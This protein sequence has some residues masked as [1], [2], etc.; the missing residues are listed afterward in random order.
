MAQPSYP[1]PDIQHELGG[2]KVFYVTK[3]YWDTSIKRYLEEMIQTK[4]VRPVPAAVLKANAK[5]VMPT[6]LEED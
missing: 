3:N 4:L 1:W 6:K 2:A 5:L